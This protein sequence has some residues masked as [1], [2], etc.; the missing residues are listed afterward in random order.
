MHG[1]GTC[2]FLLVHH[3]L[4]CWRVHSSLDTRGEEEAE[5][6]G[7]DVVWVDRAVTNEEEVLGEF[8]RES[9]SMYLSMS[10]KNSNIPNWYIAMTK[11]PL[12]SRYTS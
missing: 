4:S 3:D 8:Q 6:F 1:R 5:I 9:S 11:D 7:E 10:S 12:T 2:A